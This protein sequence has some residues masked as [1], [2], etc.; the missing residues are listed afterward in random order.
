[1]Q[2]HDGMHLLYQGIKTSQP[3]GA[4]GMLLHGGANTLVIRA[5]SD[6]LSPRHARHPINGMKRQT[7]YIIVIDI[8]SWRSRAG[9]YRAGGL[10]RQQSSGQGDF[11]AGF[12]GGMDLLQLSNLQGPGARARPALAP[13]PQQYRL[14]RPQRLQAR[15][16]LVIQ[17]DQG[18]GPTGLPAAA[19]Q[20]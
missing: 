12:L 6:T 11:T 2:C 7:N 19:A 5:S 15:L 20:P 1:M 17:A 4:S 16:L 18:C 8:C 9:S 13:G 14:V 10:R 3:L